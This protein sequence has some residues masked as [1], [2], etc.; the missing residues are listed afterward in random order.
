[1]KQGDA[2]DQPSKEVKQDPVSLDED[3]INE[4]SD[5]V[6][7]KVKTTTQKLKKRIKKMDKKHAKR[8]G[9]KYCCKMG[10][11]AQLGNQNCSDPE[12]KVLEKSLSNFRLNSDICTQVFAACCKDKLIGEET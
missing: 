12:Q 1:M 5:K 2:Q 7:K 8:R 9:K 4:E 11:N 3:E 6:N 10:M